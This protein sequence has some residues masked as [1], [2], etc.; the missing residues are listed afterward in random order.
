MFAKELAEQ[1]S[2]IPE[3]SRLLPIEEFNSEKPDDE[4]VDFFIEHEVRFYAERDLKSADIESLL[5]AAVLVSREKALDAWA[6]DRLIKQIRI[7][8]P[9]YKDDLK[10]AFLAAGLDAKRLTALFAIAKKQNRDDATVAV[11]KGI[12]NEAIKRGDIEQDKVATILKNALTKKIDRPKNSPEKSE[13]SVISSD[14]SSPQSVSP[15]STKQSEAEIAVRTNSVA[16]SETG[17]DPSRL[18]SI[19]FVSADTDTTDNSTDTVTKAAAENVANEA[20]GSSFSTEQPN[21]ER[22]VASVSDTDAQH[23][24]EAIDNSA[25]T[26]QKISTVAA[27]VTAQTSST[28]LYWR[29]AGAANFIAGV[30]LMGLGTAAIATGIFA[31]VGIPLVVAG[32]CVLAVSPITMGMG[33][34]KAPQTSQAVKIADSSVAP[35]VENNPH[36]SQS[37]SQGIFSTVCNYFR[38]P[39]TVESLY[40]KLVAHDYDSHDDQQLKSEIKRATPEVKNSLWGK[41]WDSKDITSYKKY[42]ISNR[43]Y[44]DMGVPFREFSERTAP[45][46]DKL[47]ADKTQTAFNGAMRGQSAS[48]E[49][50][51]VCPAY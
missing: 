36:S 18:S 25:Q 26:S 7:I 33:T 49:E 44:R 47:N 29:A 9:D 17:T 35:R 22:A 21:D 11:L 3:Q 20:A 27:A 5:K 37:S 6:Y 16:E 38:T 1:V 19:S 42:E 13:A 12:V 15:I 8:K 24:V 43:F 2:I 48:I 32:A 23:E 41:I 34:S 30:L 4:W 50:A 28:N 14:E 51:A 40:D 31:A 10:E 39:V 45:V 46:I